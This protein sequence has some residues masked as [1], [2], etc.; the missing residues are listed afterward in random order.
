[1]RLAS[2]PPKK[3]T[4]MSADENRRPPLWLARWWPSLVLLVVGFGL[5]ALMFG[6][7]AP[8]PSVS[9]T[10]AANDQ[11]AEGTIWTC[12]M[13]PQ[14]RQSEPG[15]CPICG[16]DLIPVNSN[17]A[18]EDTSGRV[19]LSK[20]ARALARLR[21]SEVKRQVDNSSELRLLGLVE[22]N[23]TTLK[24]VTAWTGGRIDKLHV[25]TTGQHVNKGQVI[26]TL[27]SPEVLAAHQDLIVAKRQ[28]EQL[29]DAVESAKVA[30]RQALEAS[31]ARLRLL[32][33]P[34]AELTRL[35]GASRPTTQ[36]E[37]RSPFGGTVMERIA[38]EGAYVATGA[39]LFRIANLTSLWLQL[40]AYE[41]DL[42]R[43]ELGQNVRVTV[44]AL[45]GEV[46]EG[47]VTFIDPSLDPIKRTAKLRVQIQSHGGRLRPGMFAEAVVEATDRSNSGSQLVVPASAPLFTGRRALIYVEV[48]ADDRFVYEPRTVRLGPKVGD[49]Y[50]VVAGLREGE[51]VVTRGAFAL[52]A[53]LQIQGGP[54]MMTRPDD[55]QVEEVREPIR[56][57]A[58]DR[59]G[60]AP[61]V[62]GYLGVQR[63]LAE[64]D[65]E[66]AKAAA[67]SLGKGLEKVRLPRPQAA[68]ELWRSLSAD[69]RARAQRVAAATAIE[70]A[71]SGFEALSGSVQELVERFGN[72]LGKPLMLAHCPMAFG[73]QG[74]SWLQQG[75]TIDNS[76]FGASMRSCGEV[77]SSVEPGSFLT[78][79]PQQSG[80]A[81]EHEPREGHQH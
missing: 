68:V 40:D 41:S 43:L 48:E 39:P 80:P 23:E 61:V 28:V 35:E 3:N 32:G 54:S 65:L 70:E 52:D 63:A 55:T 62:E 33:I 44:E 34:D 18:S 42:P 75:E 58:S 47:K 9:D 37:I 49:Q 59:A 38:T 7:S 76:Y 57:A 46:F 17:A 60:L 26:A 36:I 12:S 56:L 13:H 1:M 8:A 22:P 64:D 2:R 21:T 72:P 29:G 67:K 30:A 20:R 51:R 31:R 16:M 25:N 24:T 6:A 73:S 79:E 71:R 78:V 4:T 53:D 69:L 10:E 66:A 11:P 5:G 50:P 27:Y 45:P 81:H 74:A 77:Q 15:Q 14:I 19:V